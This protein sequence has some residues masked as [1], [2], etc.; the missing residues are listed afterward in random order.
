MIRKSDWQEANRELMAENRGRLGEPPTAE[1]LLA[2]SRGELSAEE[3]ARVRELLVCD[4]DLARSFTIAFPTEGATP[5]DPDY[6]T[7][8][9]FAKHW[10]FLQKRAHGAKAGTQP[11]AGGRVLQFWQRT[12]AALAAALVLAFGGLLWQA[13]SRARLA[14]EL[15][16]PRVASEE[17]LLLPDGQRG[18][19]DGSATLSTEGDFYLLVVPLIVPPANGGQIARNR[20]QI[21]DLSANPPLP[22]WSST[23]LQRRD[24]DTFAILVPRTFL[25]PGKYQI[26]LYGA[27]GGREERLT[28][29]SL[30]VPRR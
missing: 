11:S 10:E 4:P 5:G 23:A 8:A 28:S 17:Q 18:G 24:N 25:K 22:L 7:D 6:L 21:V 27:D 20:L 3:E 1:K 15:A 14:K 2:Y 16:E 9:E 19:G 30:R 29:Y 13:Q 26:V 12:S